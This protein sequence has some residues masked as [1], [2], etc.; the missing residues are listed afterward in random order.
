M[1]SAYNMIWGAFYFNRTPM[2]PPGCKIIVHEK[3]GKRMSWEFHGIPGFTLD[4]S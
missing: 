3:P 1:I 2:G 4:L